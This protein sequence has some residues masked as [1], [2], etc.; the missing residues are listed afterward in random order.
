MASYLT[1]KKI[2][3]FLVNSLR[4]P[5]ITLLMKF[6]K[7]FVDSYIISV[8]QKGEE[9]RETE[10]SD[11]KLEDPYIFQESENRQ[12]DSDSKYS[13]KRYNINNILFDIFTNVYLAEEQRI[14]I[15][16]FTNDASDLRQFLF[17]E[18]FK[19]EVPFLQALKLASQRV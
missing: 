2:P 1:S 17:T 16:T 13:K 11:K 6:L 15:F 7:Y 10:D 12:A 8:K 18:I 19:N 4:K 9:T 3:V 5:T 14:P